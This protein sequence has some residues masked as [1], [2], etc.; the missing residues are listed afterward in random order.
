MPLR[1]YNTLTREKENFAP[2]DPPNVGFYSCGPTVYNYAHI[3]NLRSYV[4]A[5]IIQKTLEYEEY[6]VKRVMNITDIGHLVNDSDDGEDK[7]AKGLKREGKPF[8][9]E[10]MKELAIFYKDKFM[11]DLSA[12][13]IKVPEIVPFASDHIKEDVEIIKKLLEKGFAYKTSDGIYFEIAKFPDYWNL[14]KGKENPEGKT[15]SRI[16]ENNE[17][18]NQADF[19]LWKYSEKNGLGY[20]A[21]IGKGFPGWHIECSGMGIKYLGE[22]FDIHTGGIDHIPVHHTNEIAQSEAATG[23]KPFVKFWMHNEFLDISSG[24]K[25]AKS[26]ENFITLHTVIEK[27][28]SPL[29]YRFWLLMAHYRTKMNF[30]WE[31]LEGAETALKRLYGLYLGLG[32]PVGRVHQEYQN[33]FKEYLEDDLDTPKALTILWDVFR[34]ENIS[35]A[36]KK[37][38]VLDFDKVLGLG[39]E[40]VEKTVKEEIIPENILKLAEERKLA[41][42]NKDFKK[43]DE[44]RDEINSLGYEIKDKAGEQKISKI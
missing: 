28:I 39:F 40:Q 21:E 8:T 16:E 4:L 17:K 9:L 31:A 30:N 15:E 34:D 6:K 22:Q 38:T 27:R 41:R 32:E 24:G 11:E 23:K 37:A 42:E 19:A 29:A 18:K 33:K 5:D 35:N 13:N 25:M 3:G 1:F 36:D 43:S 7:M 10:A 20:D 26:G 14:S 2:I 12:M 44:L